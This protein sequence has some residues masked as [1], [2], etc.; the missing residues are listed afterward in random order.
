MSTTTHPDAQPLA[1]Y[2][3]VAHRTRGGAAT[4][5]LSPC[6]YTEEP[7]GTSNHLGFS[8]NCSMV[9]CLITSW[10]TAA[11]PVRRTI[12]EEVRELRDSIIA[13]TGLSRQEIARAIGVDRRSLSGYVSGEI[14]PTE[15]RLRSLR[16]LAEISEWAVDRFGDYARELL[17]GAAFAKPPLV[18]IGERETDV[19]QVLEAGARAL[20][21]SHSPTITVESRPTRPPLHH[22]ALSVWAQESSLPERGG[23]P[24]EGAVYEQDLARAPQSL[25]S[26]PIPRRRQI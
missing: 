14:R 18:L 23:A 1:T 25:D 7:Y 24:R 20:R 22:H 2:G 19:R 4:V 8:V 10:V 5:L 12:A 16:E 3:T 13:R 11:A 17:R 26:Q 9:Q 21:E 15:D 6:Q